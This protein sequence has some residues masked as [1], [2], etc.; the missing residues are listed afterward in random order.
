MKL[1]PRQAGSARRD[2]G[3]LKTPSHDLRTC[4]IRVGRDERC[5]EMG[6]CCL[7][8]HLMLNRVLCVLSMSV[9]HRFK[10]FGSKISEKLSILIR[11]LGYA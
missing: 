7:R 5:K 11:L 1:S 10:L 2:E 9:N 3:Y 4:G 6:Y 8:C